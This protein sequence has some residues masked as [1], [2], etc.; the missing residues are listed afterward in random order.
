MNDGEAIRLVENYSDMILKI[1]FTYLK[2]VSDSEDICQDIFLKLLYHPMN[3]ESPEHEKAWIM[4]TTIN[5][6]KDYL[7]SAYRRRILSIEN[8]KT[9]NV[10]TG[11]EQYSIQE[12]GIV[13]EAVM[14]LSRNQR[15]SI[16]LY[17]YEEYSI[18]EISEI[19]GKTENVI[20]S[21]LS[22][23]RRKMQKLLQKYV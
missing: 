11:I 12:H 8:V 3:F 5:Q 13:L 14:K 18:K 16:Y 9:E 10:S 19:L 2:S 6:C 1:S 4:K 17:Y 15:L 7:K 20:A 23:G 22:R 21:Y